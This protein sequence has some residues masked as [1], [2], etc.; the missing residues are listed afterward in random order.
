MGPMEKESDQEMSTNDHYKKN[1]RTALPQIIAV[2]V[3]NLLLLGY[4]MTLGFP[5]ILIPAVSQPRDG[6][7]LHLNASEVSWI[8]SI[9]LIVVPLGCA[10]SGVVT[11]P[12][13]RRRAMQAVNLP[14]FIAWLMFYFS[15]TTGHLYGALFLT[16]LAGGLLEAPVLTYVAEITQPYLRGSLSAT[17]SM[18]I[19]IGVFTQFL[20][21]LLMYWRTVALVN[22]TFTILAVVALFFVPESP[23]WLVSRKRHADAR[24]S[25]QWLRG[26]TT[27]QA[28]EA[29]LKDIQALFKT[30]RAEADDVEELWT[31]KLSHY[32][33]RSFLVPFFLVSFSFFVGHFSGM[34]TLQTY[35][36]S[37][38]QALD[39]P[40]DK[41]RATLILGAVQ[42][43]GAG[44]CVLLV[45][46]TG[47]RTLTLVSTAGAAACCLLLAAYD[48]H[49]KLHARPH[50]TLLV[51]GNL[52]ENRTLVD[53][54]AALDTVKN[55]YSWIPTSLLMLLALITHT[56]IR[57]LPWI[58]IGEVFSAKTRS[59]GAGLTSGLGY[60]FG[61]LTNKIF[62]NMVDVLSIWGTYGF[63]GLICLTGSVVFYF[64]LPETE[65]K[66][67]NDIENHFAGIKKLT[68]E[69]YRSQKRSTVE[70]SKMRDLK[71]ATNPTFEG[72]NINI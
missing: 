31:E 14:F 10:M 69:V 30:K 44:A 53:V 42:L 8:G 19:I 63:Y 41:Y 4:G 56:G 57:L 3:K 15:S 5:T 62:I 1:L 67:L 32:L 66:K 9:N 12:L 34:T 51:N 21:G 28:V 40:L 35:A 33:D 45:R 60:M 54:P 26:W 48:L 2:S 47:K 43:A 49:M 27:P 38:F 58:L 20:F 72:D 13:G 37:I 39:A 71:G 16:G 36:V 52:E 7:V 25:L 64:I 59:G 65:G 17:S 23:H 55:P 6:E 61:F 68:N 50:S 22:I 46:I 70:V 29:E 18:C 11:S 24:K